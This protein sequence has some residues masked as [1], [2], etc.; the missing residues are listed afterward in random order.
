MWRGVKGKDGVSKVGTDIRCDAC[1]G[2]ECGRCG[3]GEWREVA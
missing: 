1:G 3:R 2:D